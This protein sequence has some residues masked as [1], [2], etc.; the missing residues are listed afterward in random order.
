[1]S[2]NFQMQILNFSPKTTPYK[3][4][5]FLPGGA[6][7]I[8]KW[9][10]VFTSING[11]D[12]SP[13]TM[14]ALDSEAIANGNAAALLN[15][16]GGGHNGSN[17]TRAMWYPATPDLTQCRSLW[18]NSLEIRVNQRDSSLISIANDLSQV[19]EPTGKNREKVWSKNVNFF[20]AGN[21]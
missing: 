17:Y 7:G 20:C 12:H 21:K 15:G 5:I 18:L 19:R 6:T 8:A 4:S 13:A 9:R 14:M 10:C 1:M 3:P 2:F 11:S 16:N